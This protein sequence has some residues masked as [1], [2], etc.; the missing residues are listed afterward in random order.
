MGLFTQV[1]KRKV[2]K[3][4]NDDSFE[5]MDLP[6]HDGSVVKKKD[7]NIVEG[8][9]MINKLQIPFDGSNLGFKKKERI[10]II[11]ETDIIEDPFNILPPGEKPEEGPGLIKDYVQQK[12]NSVLYR[13]QS[14]PKSE[15]TINRVVLFLGIAII[16]LVLIALISLLKG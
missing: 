4:Y 10:M 12:A 13:H 1:D 14:N 5:V 15:T 16:G 9:P 3:F 7:G 11:S 6:T 8:W 2:I